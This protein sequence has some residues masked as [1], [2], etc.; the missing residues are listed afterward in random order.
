MS[1]ENDLI[2]RV[3]G[4]GGEGVVSTG[5]FIAAACARAGLEVYTFKTFPA[6]VRG[7]YC[8]YQIRVSSDRVYNQGDTF[9]VFCAFNGEAYELN[10]HLLTPGT[11]FVYDYPGGDFQPDSIPEGVTAYAIPM[12]QAAKELGSY[13][14]KNM[15][16]MGALS[17]LFNINEET[18]KQVLSNKFK[19]KGEDI[20]AFNLQAFDK[21]KELGLAH[22]KVDSWR[23]ADPQGSKDVIIISGN[24]AVGLG[25]VLGGLEFFSAYPITP[26]TEIAKFVATHLPKR[27]GTLVQAEDEIASIGQVMG[28]S[29]AGK[30]SMTATSGPGLSLMSE[31]LGM[32]FMGEIPALVVDVQ[33]GGPSTGLPTKHEQSD[34]YLAM[35]GTHGDA[36]RIVLSVEDVKD[37]IDM[38]VDALNMAEQYQCPV[39]LL[40]DGSLA[41]STQTVPTPKP[42][43]YTLVSRKRW[44]GQGKYF[45]Y[46]MTEDNISPMADPGTPGGE[47]IATGL[48]HGANGAPLWAPANHEAMQRKRTNKING[49]AT[50][51]KPTE[52]DGAG[53]ADVGIIAWGSTIGVAREAVARLRAEGIK[54]KGFYPKLMWPMPVAQYEAFAA[55][56]KQILVPE[57]NFQGQLAHFIRAETSIK[58]ISYTICGGLPF[59][60]SM[61][62]NKVKEVL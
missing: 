56:C 6:E 17:A 12:S 23:V 40:S 35:H 13:R 2:I 30:K 4:E 20:L 10:K 24:D 50:S 19:K 9:N 62:V 55:T 61:I 59:N 8:M 60:P 57:V 38:T 5:D 34:L 42:D 37:C 46:L 25:A 51:Y 45:R 1:K 11:S 31:M 53:E 58:P 16:A 33:R 29:Y 47:H 3:A 26:A 27:G 28:A 44:D 39:I 14:S 22:K 21:G 18:L 7:G 52:V 54:V 15:V 41:F 43:N 49:L 36:P 32:A 48:E